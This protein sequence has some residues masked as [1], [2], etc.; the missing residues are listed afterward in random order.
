MNK[1]LIL[2]FLLVGAVSCTKA[3]NHES[4]SE[5]QQKKVYYTCS[6]HPQVKE[7]KPGKCPICHMNLT[8][9]EEEVGGSHDTHEPVKKEVSLYY[10]K[11][12]PDVTSEIPGECP[13]D[14]TPMLQKSTHQKAQEIVAKIKLRKSQL[15]HFKPSYFPASKMPMEK[16]VRLLGSVFQS[17]EKESNIPARVAGRVEK[18]YVKSTGSFVKNSAPVVDI[19]SPQLITAGEEYLLARNSYVKTGSGEFKDLLKQS[20]ERLE[21]W[22]IRKF[23]YESWFKRQKVPRQITIY[24]NATGIVRKKNASVGKYFKEGQN[25]F[26]LSDL[27]S[28]WVEMDVY[29]HDSALVELGQKVELEFTAI[30]GELQKGEID[31]IDPVL[32]AKSRTLKVRATIE[33]KSGKLK[34]GMIANATLHIELGEDVLVVPRSAIIDTGK[35]KVVWVKQN[36][37]EFRAKLIRTGVESDGY[38][39][40]KEGLEQGEEVVTEG[41]FL[42]DAQ[43]QLFGGY[44]DMTSSKAHNH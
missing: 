2:L 14:G 26:E 40:V 35:R 23:Q 32:D 4:H 24:S 43:A 16:K 30:P 34:P 17:E 29:E 7:D 3:D 5:A 11:D 20:K 28:V 15:Q 39:E 18:V 41:N 6:M 8:K 21:L 31:F 22:G 27:S 42:L 12:Y 33:N 37:K 1:F 38:V 10:C 25:F 44:E 36:E 13:I 9:V 19:Y